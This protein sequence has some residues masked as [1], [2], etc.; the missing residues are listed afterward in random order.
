VEEVRARLAWARGDRAAADVALQRCL[1]LDP[2]CAPCID[3]ARAYGLLPPVRAADGARRRR[4]PLAAN[5]L[6]GRA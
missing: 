2:A 5:V 3:L 4:S 1:T 6:T